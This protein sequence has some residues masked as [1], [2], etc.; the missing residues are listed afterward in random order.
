MNNDAKISIIMPVYNA[1]RFLPETIE[2]LL[3]QTHK[4]IE[5][6][7]V[8]DGS[9]DR[10]ME[11]LNRFSQQDSRIRVFEQKNSGPAAARNLGLENATGEYLMFCDSDDTYE[12][13]MCELML[14][15]LIEN[16]VDFATCDANTIEYNKN[17]GRSHIIINYHHIRYIGKTRLTPWLKTKVNVLL[18]NKIFKMSII[19]ANKISFPTGYESDDNA[20][21][22]QYLCFADSFYGINRALYNYKILNNSIMGKIYHGKKVARVFDRIHAA[23][24]VLNFMQKNN[25]LWHDLWI[26]MIIEQGLFYAEDKLS[27]R[28]TLKYVRSTKKHLLSFFTEEQMAQRDLLTMMHQ[29]KCRKV[30]KIIKE[31]AVRH[32]QNKEA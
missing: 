14:R 5:I 31:N 30:A 24:F 13:E 8:N 32:R 4:N 11:I 9:V 21:I 10:S 17:H 12:P 1:E 29:G 16:D 27:Y 28:N 18:W 22:W 23:R 25:I 20:F 26:L 3:K 19:R 7:C 15:A 2:S 6:L